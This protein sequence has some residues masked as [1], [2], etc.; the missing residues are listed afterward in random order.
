MGAVD[1]IPSDSPTALVTGAS[2]GIGKEIAR[3]L[4]QQGYRVVAVA[5]RAE[6]LEQLRDECEPGLIEPLALD[7]LAPEALQELLSTYTTSE[8]LPNIVVNNAGFGMNGPFIASDEERFQN[9][10]QLDFVVPLRLCRSFGDAMASRGQ[11]KI[12]N[13]ASVAG[14]ISAPYHAVY[15]AT[16]AAFLSFSEAVHVELKS[17][18]VTVSCLCPGVTETEF[19]EA[20]GYNTDSPV[21]RVQRASAQ[22]VAIAGINGLL[23]GR[24]C[25]VPGLSN[26]SLIFLARILPRAWVTRIAGRVMNTNR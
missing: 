12:L 17:S 3:Y 1:D 23:K 10:V 22:S 25:I 24:P 9:L 2:S 16:K 7:L 19:F 18:G 5:R 8:R 13:V 6:R 4:T 26:R 21:Y 15:S 14:F 11:G 20:G